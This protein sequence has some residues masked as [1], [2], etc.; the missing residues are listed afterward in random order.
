MQEKKLNN[1]DIRIEFVG[2]FEHHIR[3][4][5]EER[6]QTKWEKQMHMLEVA[7]LK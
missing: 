4:G 5:L 1:F 6:E 2:H 3:M 7:Q